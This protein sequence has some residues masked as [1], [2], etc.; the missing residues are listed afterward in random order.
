MGMGP[1]RVRL[2]GG[3]VPILVLIEGTCTQ[4]NRVL[5]ERNPELARELQRTLL[6]ELCATLCPAV[7]EITG[8]TVKTGLCDQAI[9]QDLAFCSF[10]LD[11]VPAVLSSSRDRQDRSAT[12]LGSGRSVDQH[13]GGPLIPRPADPPGHHLN[14][15]RKGR[16]DGGF[17]TPLGAKRSQAPGPSPRSETARSL[18]A[19]VPLGGTRATARDPLRLTY[20]EPFRPRPP[21]E[22]GLPRQERIE[23]RQRHLRVCF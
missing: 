11:A 14:Q 10:V 16:Q 6:D 22:L 3:G 13:S 23:G 2:L 9:E 19:A 12:G 15:Q 20:G 7:E 4:M 8:V 1:E 17:P 21:N 5:R 18:V